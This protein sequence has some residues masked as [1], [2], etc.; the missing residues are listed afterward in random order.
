MRGHDFSEIFML[1]KMLAFPV[2]R[3]QTHSNYLMQQT[4]I[5]FTLLFIGEAKSIYLEIPA[6]ENERP[7]FGGNNICMN[8]GTV[9]NEMG[10]ASPAEICISDMK[11]ICK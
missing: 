3:T 5:K 2:T 1:I 11:L 9:A 10:E 7:S 6:S 8:I 4:N